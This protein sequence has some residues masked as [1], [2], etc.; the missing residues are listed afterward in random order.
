VGLKQKLDDPMNMAMFTGKKHMTNP[1][2]DGRGRFLGL[3]NSSSW[4]T[5]P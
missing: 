5:S 3:E 1:Q 4:M 2:H